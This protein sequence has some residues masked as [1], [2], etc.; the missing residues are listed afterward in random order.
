MNRRESRA[1]TLLIF[2]LALLVF[3]LAS[4]FQW[5][6]TPGGHGIPEELGLPLAI[7]G[8]VM[9]AVAGL[10]LAWGLV[11]TWRARP[12]RRPPDDATKNPPG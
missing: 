10:S 2:G 5:D 7:T 3:G 11:R 1:P 8:V 6:P 12:L 9:L 4:L